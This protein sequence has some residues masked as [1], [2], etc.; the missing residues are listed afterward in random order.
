MQSYEYQYGGITEVDIH[1]DCNFRVNE[2]SQQVMN[3][4]SEINILKNENISLRKNS[5]NTI[6]KVSI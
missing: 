4:E 5:N 2:L 6:V 3:L 1:G